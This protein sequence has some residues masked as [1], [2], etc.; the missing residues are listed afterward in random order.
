MFNS[1]KFILCK[2]W[3]WFSSFSL[4]SIVIE[5]IFWFSLGIF[6]FSFINKELFD[7][8]VFSGFFNSSKLNWSIILILFSALTFVSKQILSKLSFINFGFSFG[9]INKILLSEISLIGFSFEGMNKILLSEI[10]LLGFCFGGIN[11]IFL[12]EI[13]LI[14]FSFEGINK[15]LLSEISLFAFSFS[16]KFIWLIFS[17]W[18]RG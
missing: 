9:G 17:N 1:N 15:I 14:G 7:S 11:K 6:S 4:D 18:Y 16:N 5:S 2:G 3:I 10:S 12:S 13:S 8:M